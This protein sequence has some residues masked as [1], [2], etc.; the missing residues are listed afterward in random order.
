MG[1][2]EER[3]KNHLEEWRMEKWCA[4]QEWNE[5]RDRRSLIILDRKC[6]FR[7]KSSMIYD[8]EDVFVCIFIQMK[9][10]KSA[11]L[12]I[13]KTSKLNRIFF[14]LAPKLPIISFEYFLSDVAN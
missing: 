3:Q 10:K 12:K 1:E 13:H 9:K 14:G 11:L 5:I 8:C 6:I 2:N 4:S 7:L